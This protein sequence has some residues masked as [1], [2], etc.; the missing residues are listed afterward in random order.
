MKYGSN[1]KNIIIYLF[2]D[3]EKVFGILVNSRL[4]SAF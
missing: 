2:S 1:L 4:Y 3:K